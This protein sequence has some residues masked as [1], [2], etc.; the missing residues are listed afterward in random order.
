MCVGWWGETWAAYQT[1]VGVDTHL[2]V[3]P[4]K[5]DASGSDPEGDAAK[6][7]GRGNSLAPR[8]PLAPRGNPGVPLL[9]SNSRPHMAPTGT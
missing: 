9:E 5:L 3:L 4:V 1:D 2:D 6:V 7:E 8:H